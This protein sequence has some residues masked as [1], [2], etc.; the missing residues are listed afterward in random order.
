MSSSIGVKIFFNRKFII[1]DIT[2]KK[3]FFDFHSTFH[4]CKWKQ[5]FT[6]S[7]W[8]IFHIYFWSTCNH[9]VKI[10]QVEKYEIFINY[11][12]NNNIRYIGVLKIK[13]NTYIM[14]KFKH[15]T[16]ISFSFYYVFISGHFFGVNIYWVSFFFHTFL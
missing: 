12:I 9:D 8:T 6:N 4:K 10:S 1:L 5:P 15:I 14:F 11:F 2:V 16:M 7:M 3:L 13:S